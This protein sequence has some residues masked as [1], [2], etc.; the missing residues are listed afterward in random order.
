M[1]SY[2]KMLDY[3]N[4]HELDSSYA[5]IIIYLIKHI[6]NVPKLSITELANE[7]FVS[8]ATVSRFARF[9]Q[10]ENFQSLKKELT[11]P[12]QYKPEFNFRMNSKSVDLITDNPKEFLKKYSQAI[13]NSIEYVSENIDIEKVDK[14]LTLINK[15]KKLFLFGSPSSLNLLQEIQRGFFI[16]GSVIYTGETIADFERLTNYI[17]SQSFVIVLSSFGNFLSENTKLMNAIINMD[18]ETC[19]ITQH[20]ENLISTSFDHIISVTKRN[21]IEAGSYPTILFCEYFVRRYFSLFRK[22]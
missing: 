7:C 15:Q 12:S 5:R 4:T 17:D 19:F 13:I 6:N 16:S 20:T 11:L 18:C 22:K 14:I 3:L 2:I 21:Y 1:E 9:F 10:Y 8:N